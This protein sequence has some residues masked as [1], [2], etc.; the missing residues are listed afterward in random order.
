MGIT[1]SDGRANSSV[2]KQDGNGR[3]GGSA[4]GRGGGEGEGEGEGGCVATL[5][6]A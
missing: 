6:A 2:T 5:V 1:C 4:R 3:A